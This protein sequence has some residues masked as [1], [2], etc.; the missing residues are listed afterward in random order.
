MANVGEGSVLLPLPDNETRDAACV[1]SVPEESRGLLNSVGINA[2][3]SGAPLRCDPE[4]VPLRGGAG[5]ATCTLPD[6]EEAIAGANYLAILEVAL[7]YLYRSAASAELSI[8]RRPGGA[9]PSVAERDAHP[10]YV[11]GQP[12]C[13]YCTANPNDPACEDLPPEAAAAIEEGAV[14]ACACSQEECLERRRGGDPCLFGASWCPGSNYC[15]A[16]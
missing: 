14:Y 11:H 2:S 6:G 5:Y 4:A 10:G 3:L 7:D 8:I 13:T 16:D 15:C 9:A 1:G 12:R